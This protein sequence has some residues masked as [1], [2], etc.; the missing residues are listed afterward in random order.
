MAPV[1]RFNIIAQPEL[2]CLACRAHQT[3]QSLVYAEF[4]RKLLQ[5]GYMDK[6]RSRQGTPGIANKN[7]LVGYVITHSVCAA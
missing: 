5:W 7:T 1:P 3:T 2:Y 6:H 4:Y